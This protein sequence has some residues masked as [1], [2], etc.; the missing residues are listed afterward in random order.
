MT[1]F[2]QEFYLLLCMS[3]RGVE[4]VAYREKCEKREA[5]EDAG[6]EDKKI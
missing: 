6:E 5:E 4:A 2:E 3:G 1:Q